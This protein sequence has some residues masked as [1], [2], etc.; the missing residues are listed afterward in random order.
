MSSA[1][2]IVSPSSPNGGQE[3]NAPI[4][5]ALLMNGN[6]VVG[7]A[8]QDL[9]PDDAGTNQNLLFEISP[10]TGV[11][12]SKQLDTGDPGALF[13]IAAGPGADGNQ[14]IF[15]NDDNDNTVKVL[16]K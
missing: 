4:S 1:T 6:L 11:V 9:M 14:V 13:G 10:T 16:L 2:V 7:N 12:G 15:F 8:D 5:A 3:F